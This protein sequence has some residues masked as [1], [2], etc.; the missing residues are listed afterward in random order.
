MGELIL[1]FV[2]D[3]VHD[4]AHDSAHEVCE[5]ID[6]TDGVPDDTI[7]VS[8]HCIGVRTSKPIKDDEYEPCRVSSPKSYLYSSSSAGKED[9]PMSP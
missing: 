5:V 4:S 2:L 6:D 7:V 8:S 3:S 1:D 9:K